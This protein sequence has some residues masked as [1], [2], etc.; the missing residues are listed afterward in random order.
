MRTTTFFPYL[1]SQKMSN[2]FVYKLLYKKAIRNILERNW[3]LMTNF[4]L[5]FFMWQNIICEFIIINWNI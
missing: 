2:I 4:I 3:Y 5:I 1:L